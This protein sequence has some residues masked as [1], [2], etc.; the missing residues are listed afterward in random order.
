MLA[1]FKT[2][3]FFQHS[4][5]VIKPFMYFDTFLSWF[6]GLLFGFAYVQGMLRRKKRLLR[7]NKRGTR[8]ICVPKVVCQSSVYAVFMLSNFYQFNLHNITCVVLAYL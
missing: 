8:R 1:C 6:L 7:R 4:F 2:S 3:C 5:H